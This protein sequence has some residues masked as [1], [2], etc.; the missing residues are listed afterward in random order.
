MSRGAAR[1]RLLSSGS[2]I[3]AIHASDSHLQD[4]SGDTR[5]ISPNA[6]V[7]IQGALSVLAG[8]QVVA[9]S[10]AFTDSYVKI[11]GF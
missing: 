8:C 6:Q 11:A 1:N 7:M 5:C 10:G 9:H 3:T 2:I 4:N